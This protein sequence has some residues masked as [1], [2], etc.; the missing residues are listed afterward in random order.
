MLVHG[1]QGV[2]DAAW[3]RQWRSVLV[4]NAS[5]LVE[6]LWA[7]G[8]DEI[9]FDGSF[10]E[11]KD[12]PGDIDGYFECP[13]DKIISGDLE[14]EL[15]LLDPHT[16]WTWNELQIYA[17]KPRLPMWIRYR[18]EFY[19]HPVDTPYSFARSGI[20]DQ[21]GNDLEFPSAFR[22]SREFI[23]KGTVKVIQ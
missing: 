19:P 15:N 6:Q 7:I 16:I 13:W 8:I 17:G 9:F 10:V 12:R 20:T 5:I 14:R 3:D 11:N 2:T 4:N 22:Q 1:R 21:H 18:T 23:Q